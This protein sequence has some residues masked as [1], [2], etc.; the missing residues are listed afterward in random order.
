MIE[1][2]SNLLIS[3]G[4][5]WEHAVIVLCFIALLWLERK[6]TAKDKQLK[7]INDKLVD[8]TK[9][10]ADSQNN[11]AHTVADIATR[12]TSAIESIIRLTTH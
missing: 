10:F 1:I 8:I 6:L 7:T 5:T 2:I 11:S 12:F 9:E 4:F 3:G